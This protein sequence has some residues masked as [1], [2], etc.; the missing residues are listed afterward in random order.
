MAEEA[1][2]GFLQTNDEI[3]DSHEFAA[4]IEVDHT[5]LVNV[6]K[7][8]NGFEIL[9]AKIAKGSVKRKGSQLRYVSDGTYRSARL[10]VVDGG[11]VKILGCT[12]N[13]PRH[14]DG[15][16]RLKM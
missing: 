13:M 15:T 3:T 7:R 8:L 16:Y 14:I 11:I 1:I 4:G 10:G 9:E 2:L 12:I 5:Y 6:I